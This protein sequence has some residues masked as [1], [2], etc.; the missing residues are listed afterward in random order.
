MAGYQIISPDGATYQIT[1]PD[2]ASQ[3]DVLSYAQQNHVQSQQE[4]SGQDLGRGYSALSGFNSVVPFG[5]RITAGLGSVLAKPFMMD[6]PIGDIYNNIRQDQQ[7]TNQA[8]PWANLAG[9]GAGIIAT[10]P[11]GMETAGSKALAAQG[12]IRGAINAIPEALSQVGNFVRG[13]PLAED[14]G[15]L[16]QAGNL[17]AQSLKSAAVAAPVGA[18]YGYGDSPEGQ[19]LQGAASNAGMAAAIGGAMP[20]AGA[21]LNALNNA[22]G[23]TVRPTAAALKSVSQANYA[24]A[25]EKGGVLSPSFT[26]KFLDSIQSISPTNKW[27]SATAKPTL[28]SGLSEDWQTFRGQP[29]TLDDATSIDQHLTSLLDDPSATDKHGILNAQGKQILDIKNNLRSSLQSASEDGHIQG[30]NEGLQAYQTA[31]KDWAAQSQINDI[32]RIVDKASYAD[33]PATVM[34]NGFKAIAVNPGRLNKFSPDVQNAIKSAASSGDLT[35]ILRTEIGSRLLST[36]TGAAAGTVAGPFGSMVG[37]GAG[38]A[39]SGAARNAAEGLQMGR[40]NNVIDA[41]AANSSIPTTYTPLTAQ[42]QDKV[43]TFFD[44]IQNNKLLSSVAGK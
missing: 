21:G 44:Q 31:V 24:L 5:N 29:M 10:L 33:N 22:F 25:D 14:A 43:Q 1:A 18:L 35:N 30:G 7:T 40:V 12:G 23:K 16:A 19:R 15:K 4:N 3:Q 32:Q 9:T 27:V 2:N 28:A 37:A 39:L 38:L 20:I 6:T 13:A 36:I 42:L 17:A 34:K 8:H 11:L 41:I 26:D